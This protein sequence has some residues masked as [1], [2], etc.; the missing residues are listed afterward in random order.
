MVADTIKNIFFVGVGSFIGGGARYLISVAMK[1]YFSGAFPRGTFFVNLS[2]CFLIGL[3]AGYIN[4]QAC[5]GSVLALFLTYGVC[6]GF[7]TFSTFSRESL[8]MLQCGNYWGVIFYVTASVILGIILT[9]CGYML[10]Q[11]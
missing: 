1:N 5:E 10:L 3:F 2:G 6:G 4:R 8:L 9:A 11:Q 7:T